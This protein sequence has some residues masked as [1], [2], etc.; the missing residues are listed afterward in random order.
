MGSQRVRQDLVTQQQQFF[1]QP[2]KIKVFGKKT[3]RKVEFWEALL[4]RDQRARCFIAATC[5][6]VALPRATSLPGRGLGCARRWLPRQ[7]AP[8]VYQWAGLS[9]RALTPTPCNEAIFSD[10]LVNFGL[11]SFQAK[12]KWNVQED[13]PP[14][15]RG[16]SSLPTIPDTIGKGKYF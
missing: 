8:T 13:S 9:P 1:S 16:P 12:P 3:K 15:P 14:C 5:L 6:P 10:V 7:R 4:S 2:S 11:L